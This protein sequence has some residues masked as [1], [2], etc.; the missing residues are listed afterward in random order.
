M[1]EHTNIMHISTVNKMKITVKEHHTNIQ[2]T[3]TYEQKV[4]PNAGFNQEARLRCKS[5]QP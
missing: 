1:Y 5:R 4:K 2:T 3:M